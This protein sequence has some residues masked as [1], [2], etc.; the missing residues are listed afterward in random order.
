MGS[1]QNPNPAQYA[2]LEAAGQLQ[3]LGSPEWVTT[4]GGAVELSFP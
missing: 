1:P 4:K 3:P 2:Q